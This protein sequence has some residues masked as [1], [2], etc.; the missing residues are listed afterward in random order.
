MRRLPF[1]TEPVQVSRGFWIGLLAGAPIIAYGI[2][3]AIDHL[4][5]VQGTSFLRWFVGV[6]MVHDLLVGPLAVAAAW[7][8]ARRLPRPIVAPVQAAVLASA[9]IGLVSWP[10]V[11]AYGI[12]PGEPSFLSRNYTASLAVAWGVIWLIAAAAVGARLVRSR[13]LGRPSDG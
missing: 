6:A 5:G 2:V 10:F 1:D 9:V 4:P 11:R 7:L 13:R 12:T 8:L 3:G